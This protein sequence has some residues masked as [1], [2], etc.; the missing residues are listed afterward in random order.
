MQLDRKSVLLPRRQLGHQRV[1]LV[2]RRRRHLDLHPAIQT[3]N[4]RQMPTRFGPTL[5]D[6]A[7]PVCVTPNTLA[8]LGGMRGGPLSAVVGTCA[9]D[10]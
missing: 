5:D 10:L 1:E 7:T 3:E 8:P 6:P 9:S 4:P 2:H